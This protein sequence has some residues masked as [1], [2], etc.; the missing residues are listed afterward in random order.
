VPKLWNDTIESHRAQ[1][2][3]AICETT[4]ALVA[5][6]GLRAVTMSQIA[7][8]TGIGRATL[9]KY[10]SGVDAIM[11]AWHARKL[12][13]Q[14][15]E[16]TDVGSGEGA[17]IHRLAAV[18]VGYGR[19]MAQVGRHDREL[20]ALL[21]PGEDIAA[22]HRQLRELL[23]RVLDEGRAAGEVRDDVP[24][25]ELARYCVNALGAASEID[26][27]AALDRLVRVVLSGVASS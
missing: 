2:R 1:V 5:A 9:Y 15:A 26:S 12:E 7:V 20:T 14:L 27:A 19:S 8:E 16:L 18:L 24:V 13:T 25:D 3:E 23:A 4:A 21:E 11:R 22:A 10:F 6:H 17:P